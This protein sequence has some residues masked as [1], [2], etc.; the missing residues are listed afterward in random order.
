MSAPF[1]A[2]VSVAEMARIVGLSRSRFYQ[3]IG[4]SMP[5]P[6]RDA[7][8]RPFYSEEQQ[9]VVLDVRRR[10]CGVDGKPILFYAARGKMPVPLA[11]RSPKTTHVDEQHAGILA[12]VRGLG[13]ATT[14]T[15]QVRAA[16][17]ELFPAGVNGVDPGTVIRAVFLSIKS[18]NS[19]DNQG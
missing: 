15:A 2:A 10:H 5:E 18:Q 16:I 11:K 12:G 13:L 17:R 9:R 19:S 4:T 6:S 3:L 7:A 14:T 1:K 8:G